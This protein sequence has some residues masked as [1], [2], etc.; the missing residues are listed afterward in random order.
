MISPV[1]IQHV[2]IPR[3]RGSEDTTRAFYGQLL[4]LEEVPCPKSIAHLDLIW[5]RLGDLEIHLFAC[6]PFDDPTGRHFCFVVDDVQTASDR[7]AEAGY[8]P[9]WPE[10]IPGRPRF[11]CHD[12]FNN[13]LEFTKIE[14]NY[15]ELE[16]QAEL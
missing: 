6:D 15:L 10:V 16:A 8:K 11:F 9:W 4:G 1:R 12:P 13:T 5:F 14:A 2:S 7:L 3:P